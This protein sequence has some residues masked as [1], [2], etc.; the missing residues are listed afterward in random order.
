MVRKTVLLALLLLTGCSSNLYN[1]GRK[2]TEQGEY[3]KA[4]EAFYQDIAKYPD[5][6]AN[7]RELGVAFY[8][9]GDLV[10]AEDALKQANNIQPDARTNLYLG[11]IYERQD[12]YDKA[13]TAYGAA[14][15]LDPGGKTNNTIRA[16][17]DLLISR[18]VKSEVNLAL[19]NEANIDVDAIPENTVAVVNFDDSNLDAE[20]A[21]I[22]RGLAEFTAIDLAKVSSLRVIDRL[23]IDV[24]LE[25]LALSSSGA[26]DPATGPR[27][28]RLLGSRHLVGGSMMELGESG[29]RL[30]GVIMNTVDSS[31]SFTEPAEGALKEIFKV[32]KQF[33]FDVIDDLGIA[34]TAEERDA[35][36]EVPTESYLAFLAYCRGLDYQRR[37]LLRDAQASYEKAVEYDNNFSRAQNDAATVEAGVALGDAA[38]STSGFE[39]VVAGIA[40]SPTTPTSGLDSRLRIIGNNIGVVPD[41]TTLRPVK[42]PPPVV[43]NTTVIIRVDL[44]VDVD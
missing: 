20:T 33:V 40:P 31:A 28:G 6:A 2:L 15:G 13:I 35:I 39:A 34:L 37:G 24:I 12:M 11:L 42:A 10:K 3:E 27:M 25:E 21:P 9:K 7:W 30:D 43:G 8:E 14:L 36:S 16:H 32:Q 38:G 41:I 18:K 29:L 23:K 17:L 26:V 44:N 4:I 5:R 19:Q 1:Q 22:A